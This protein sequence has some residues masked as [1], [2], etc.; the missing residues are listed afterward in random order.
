MHNA[1]EQLPHLRLETSDVL[2]FDI[3]GTKDGLNF[4]T[5]KDGQSFKFKSGESTPL[6]VFGKA[7]ESSENGVKF[8]ESSVVLVPDG[9]R[10]A[11]GGKPEGQHNLQLFGTGM[12]ITG[13]KGANKGTLSFANDGGGTGFQMDYDNG[14]MQFATLPPMKHLKTT[15]ASQVHLSILDNGRVGVGT[16]TPSSALSIRSDT[17]ITVENTAGAKWTYRTTADGDLEFESNKGGFFKVDNQGGMHLSRNKKSPYKLEVDGTGMMLTGGEK[18]KAPLV[19]NADG[20]GEGFQMDYYKEKMMFG[21]GSG[22]KWHMIVSDAGLV[23]VGTPTPESAMH[24]KHDSG[25]AI[26]HGTKLEK[27]TIATSA[28]ASLGFSYRGK[29]HVSFAKGGFVGIGT[30]KPT[31]TLHVEG[32]V[33]VSGKLHVDNNYLKKMAK[34]IASPS[35]PTPTLERLSSAEALIQLDEHVSAKMDDQSYGIVH[36]QKSEKASESVD[37]AS[38]MTVMHRV[39]QEHQQEIKT[40]RERVAALEAKQ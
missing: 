35:T 11:I 27:W 30:D 26:E 34:K 7:S 40:L 17:G 10:A 37:Y 8:K 15:K 28:E 25:I 16:T 14:A 12:M 38:L 23:G 20:G 33:F 39:M 18:G 2:Q 1:D 9:G 6:T 22:K 36:Q 5:S 3:Q 31:K 24:V 19:F 29:P 4:G 21:H 32:D 13:G